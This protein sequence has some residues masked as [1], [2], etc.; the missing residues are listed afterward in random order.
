MAPKAKNAPNYASRPAGAK[1]TTAGANFLRV[2]LFLGG[3]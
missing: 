2:T 3:G 1:V